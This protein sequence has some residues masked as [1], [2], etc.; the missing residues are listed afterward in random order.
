MRDD[1]RRTPVTVDTILG[2]AVGCGCNLS[3]TVFLLRQSMLAPWRNVRIGAAAMSLHS[4][5]PSLAEAPRVLAAVTTQALSPS[6]PWHG[7]HTE[8]KGEEG[9]QAC[10]PVVPGWQP[11]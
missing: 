11:L 1:Y 5:C 8:D 6:L 4:M 7:L 10:A 9:T 3:A 2:T